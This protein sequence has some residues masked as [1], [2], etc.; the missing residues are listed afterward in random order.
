[1]VEAFGNNLEPGFLLMGLCIGV[2]AGLILDF[3]WWR[4]GVNKYEKRLEV[5]EHY[6]WG[7]LSLTIL[8]ML[9]RFHNVFL[10]FAGTGI[11]LIVAEFTQEHPFA[12]RSN[13]QMASTII[14][15][16]FVV[17]MVLTWAS[18]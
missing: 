13:H 17:A 11:C 14:G 5:F 6:H 16:A 10:L 18:G 7:M 12:L 8:K 3:L 2:L 4:L 15:I 9:L 1:M